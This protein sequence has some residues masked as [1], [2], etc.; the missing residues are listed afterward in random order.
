MNRSSFARISLGALALGASVSGWLKA[1]CG[2]GATP[3][4]GGI[5]AEFPH[6]AQPARFDRVRESLDAIAATLHDTP[7]QQAH[8]LSVPIYTL[9]TERYEGASEAWVEVTRSD[10][11]EPATAKELEDS[12]RYMRAAMLDIAT[13]A[14][15]NVASIDSSLRIN[16]PHQQ[17]RAT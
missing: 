13:V 17:V 8:W 6:L 7:A 11:V 10:L 5:G 14:L 4:L 1:L 16:M 9:L 2:T 15:L 3:D 12:R